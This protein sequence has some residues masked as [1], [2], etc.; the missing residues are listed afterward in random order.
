MYT[1]SYSSQFNKDLKLSAKRGYKVDML[2][3]VIKKLHETGKLEAIYRPHRLQGVYNN[4]ME[5]HI[6]PY[7][8]L[9]W[10]QNDTTKEIKFIRTGTHDDLF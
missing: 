2:L 9:I 10:Q 8:L 7:W 4:Y 1:L 5:C 6:R 3:A